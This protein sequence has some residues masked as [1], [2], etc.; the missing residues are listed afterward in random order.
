[1]ELKINL[2]SVASVVFTLSTNAYKFPAKMQDYV[3]VIYLVTK[4][5]CIT[6]PLCAV[7]PALEHSPLLGGSCEIT[8]AHSQGVSAVL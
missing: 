3:N 2:N 6:V 4:H 1:M 7:I 8:S 5:T